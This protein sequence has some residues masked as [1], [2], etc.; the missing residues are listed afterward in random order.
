MFS[1][2]NRCFEI[3]LIINNG[4]NTW[5]I[6]KETI[7]VIP[8]SNHEKVDTSLIFHAGMSNEAAVTVANQFN[9][10]E[11]SL[12]P[13]YMKIDSDQFFNIKMIC[14]HLGSEISVV[15]PDLH[16]VTSCDI[17]S[18]KFNAEKF[19][20]FFKKYKNLSNLTLIKL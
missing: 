2:P 18:Y 4:E 5:S 12:I 14:D 3:P 19:H 13:C 8:I 16:A 17:T 7:E 10:L 20:I 1:F 15:A 9:Q 6:I 11:C